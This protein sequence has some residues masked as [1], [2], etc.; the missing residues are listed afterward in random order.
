MTTHVAKSKK[1][2]ELWPPIHRL[3]Y[4]SGKTAWQVA[5]MVKR[6]RE[7]FPTKEEAETRAAQIRQMV[8]NEGAAAS[9]SVRMFKSN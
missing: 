7:A 8:D 1:K 9:V 4:T 2:K 6:I 5:C 3:T